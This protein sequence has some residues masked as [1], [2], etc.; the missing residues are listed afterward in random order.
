M[1][2]PSWR[3]DPKTGR[4]GGKRDWWQEPRREYRPEKSAKERRLDLLTG[5]GGSRS[6]Y[7]DRQSLLTGRGL[8][9]NED[10]MAMLT[11]RSDPPK[12]EWKSQYGGRREYD[13]QDR[14]FNRQFN[15]D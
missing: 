3:D 11:G 10:R 12:E 7:S 6:S 4:G 9:S 2:R 15:K 14:E 5:G 8:S 1:S 13:P